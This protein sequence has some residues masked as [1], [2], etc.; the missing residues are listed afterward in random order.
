M[1][2]RKT[3]TTTRHSKKKFFTKQTFPTHNTIII[4]ILIC[5]VIVIT[6]I[7]F[8]PLFQKKTIGAEVQSAS[9]SNLHGG[10]LDEQLKK[11]QGDNYRTAKIIFYGDRSKPQIALTFDGDMTAYMRDN[12]KSGRVKSYYDPRI[13]D[14]LKRTQTKATF[15]L[16]GMFIELYP[17]EVAELAGNQLFE[18][19]N[20][21]YSHP[22]FNGRCYGLAQVS[23]KK[24]IEEIYITQKLLRDVTSFENKYFRFPGGC[25]SEK[26]IA[27]IKNVADLYIVHWDVQGDDGF[28]MNTKSIIDKVVSQT[29]NGSIILLHLNG[30]PNS[31][32]TAEALPSIIEQLRS[33]GFEFRKL[34]ELLNL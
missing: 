5:L 24:G 12:V 30:P 10:V 7:G 17:K 1:K 26:D 14:I 29:R 25:Y 22:S 23:D 21:S 31:P 33:K 4:C 28:N 18:L 6:S 3:K 16:S 20:H 2:K 34:S 27:I 8:I 19:G 32:K 11:E 13:V 9:I 15:F